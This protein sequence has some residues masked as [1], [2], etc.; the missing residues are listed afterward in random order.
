[1]NK[2]RTK[3]RELLSQRERKRAERE[4]QGLE[5]VEQEPFCP[6]FTPPEFWNALKSYFGMQ[7]LKA[8][9]SD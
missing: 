7:E 3:E 2:L 8:K 5:I 9:S 1:M 6:D 4:S